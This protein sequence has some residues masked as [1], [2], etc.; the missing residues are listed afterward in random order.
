MGPSPPETVA[1]NFI[2]AR[3]PEVTAILE[4]LAAL[5]QANRDE[6]GYRA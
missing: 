2:R 4:T 5:G 3:I 6:A 1:R